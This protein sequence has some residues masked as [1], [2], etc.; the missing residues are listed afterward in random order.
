MGL[1]PILR[2]VE[3]IVS[4]A[5]DL[6]HSLVEDR[7]DAYG[8]ILQEFPI[9]EVFGVTADIAINAKLGWDGH[10]RKC[11]C[12]D[13]LEPRKHTPNICLRLL[14]PPGIQRIAIYLVQA[15]TGAKLYPI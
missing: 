6:V 1:S 13:L 4:K 5:I 9:D 8:A 2:R 14:G 12:G 15:L 7:H 11:V 3:L 10:P